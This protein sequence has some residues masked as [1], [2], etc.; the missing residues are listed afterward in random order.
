MAALQA[1]NGNTRGH[2][3]TSSSYPFCRV[4]TLDRF[5][6]EDLRRL[7]FGKRRGLSA[8]MLRL[9]ASIMLMT[10][11]RDGLAGPECLGT[12]RACF[13]RSMCTIAFR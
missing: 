11:S 6:G 5:A 13:F 10:F 9:K 1:V 2:G 3:G 4:R 12:S 8:A 7:D